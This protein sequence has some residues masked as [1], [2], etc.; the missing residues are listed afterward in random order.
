MV[1]ILASWDECK[2]PHG[3]LSTNGFAAWAG[4]IVINI[5]DRKVS[6]IITRLLPLIKGHSR[7]EHSGF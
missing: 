2:H 5:P 7:S 3:G 6:T 4:N 1:Q